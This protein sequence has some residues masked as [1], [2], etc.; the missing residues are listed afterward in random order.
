MTKSPWEA[1]KATREGRISWR[2]IDQMSGAPDKELV[3]IFESAG[4]AK[5][6]AILAAAGLA[7]GNYATFEEAA[8]AEWAMDPN[9]NEAVTDDKIA[10]A[11]ER[12]KDVVG[13][14]AHKFVRE[15]NESLRTS[16]WGTPLKQGER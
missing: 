15:I 1:A 5:Q 16:P 6:T 11:A 14:P 7:R 12:A 3:Y 2:D 10:R 9:E 13:T 8:I 4:F